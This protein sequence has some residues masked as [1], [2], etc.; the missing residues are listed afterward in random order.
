MF[1]L[2]DQSPKLVKLTSLL[3]PLLLIIDRWAKFLEEISSEIAI[4]KI[5]DYL[6]RDVEC[7]LNSEKYISLSL[8]IDYR[9]GIA[10]FTSFSRSM[11]TNIMFLSLIKGMS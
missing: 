9:K 1:S 8:L 7:R 10:A 5:V 2:L 6:S 11:F 4:A 3:L